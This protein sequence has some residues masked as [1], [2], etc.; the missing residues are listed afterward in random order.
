[1]KYRFLLYGLSHRVL[2]IDITSEG[3]ETGP[4]RENKD[5]VPILRFGSR[6]AAAAHL[7]WL[8]ADKEQL[9]QAAASFRRCSMASLTI[10]DRPWS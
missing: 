4:R 6:D 9:E 5:A 1:M 10:L 8:G 2:A 3:I 7:L